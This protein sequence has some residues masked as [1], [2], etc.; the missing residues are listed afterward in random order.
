MLNNS[1]FQSII[2]IG[3]I[4]EPVGLFCYVTDS[5]SHI[6]L[7]FDVSY[8]IF[9]NKIRRKIYISIRSH[10]GIICRL[11]ENK[12]AWENEINWIFLNQ[13]FVQLV[14]IIYPNFFKLINI[15]LVN[16]YYYTLFKFYN[17]KR[18]FTKVADLIM[19]HNRVTYFKYVGANAISFYVWLIVYLKLLLNFL[20]SIFRNACRFICRFYCVLTLE[21]YKQRGNE[22]GSTYAGSQYCY[23][24]TPA[25]FISLPIFGFLNL[26]CC[27]LISST[28]T[29]YGIGNIVDTGRII[30]HR[31]LTRYTYPLRFIVGVICIAAGVVAFHLILKF[32]DSF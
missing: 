19:E 23:C 17:S 3:D 6:V 21:K 29:A 8:Q 14:H 13:I 32:A 24:I 1:P 22:H 31:D 4:V 2:F 5:Y 27:A 28:L 9:I 18:I 30:F 26:V 15:W 10:K 25:L 16:L 7:F 12:R 20:K 11:I